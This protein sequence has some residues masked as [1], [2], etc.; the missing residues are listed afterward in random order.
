MAQIKIEVKETGAKEAEKSLNKLGKTGAKTDKETQSLDKTYQ[1]VSTTMGKYTGIAKGVSLGLAA[2]GSATV[3]ATVKTAAYIVELDNQARLSKQSIADYEASAFAAEQYG[4]TVDQLSDAFKDVSEKVGEFIATGGGG[5]ADFGDVM[6]MTKDET[7]AFAKEVEHLSGQEVLQRMTNELES[8]GASSAQMSFAL[9]GMASYLTLLQPLLVDNGSELKRLTTA[10][11]ELTIPIDEE[12]VASFRGLNEATGLLTGAMTSLLTSG[13][14]PMVDS[15]TALAE[16]TAH[17]VASLNEGTQAQL[18][19]D[20]V[21]LDDRAKEL[22]AT[23]E[24]NDDA[25]IKFG[26]N[27][28]NKLKTELAEVEAKYLATQK[29]LADSRVGSTDAEFEFEGPLPQ[30]AEQKAAE[31]SKR[32]EALKTAKAKEEAARQAMEKAQELA[33]KEIASTQAAID[34]R[35]AALQASFLTEAEIA[36]QKNQLIL[37]SSLTEQEQMALR[38]QLWGEYNDSVTESARQAAEEQASIEEK[39]QADIDANNKRMSDAWSNLT[40][41]LKTSLGEQNALYK[42]SATINATIAAYDAA[43]SAYAALAPIPYVGPALGAAAAG[44]A[45]AAGLANVAKINSARMQGGQVTAGTPYNVNERSSGGNSEVFVPDS[46]GKIIPSHQV[47]NDSNQSG[48]LNVNIFNYGSDEVSAVEEDDGS[49]SI[50]IKKS[51]FND[52]MSQQGSNA[53]SSLN[54]AQSRTYKMT[55]A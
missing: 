10:M 38:L 8:A 2:I 34:A 22:R 53:N 52:L 14:N 7:T 5:M 24:G 44:V 23:I 37:D 48:G 41:D 25:W 17:W 43:N 40:G 29:K 55:R 26:D 30:T 12:D 47:G 1:S 9:E 28:L 27:D 39:K 54:Q 45:V 16:A 33:D 31:E 36:K 15:M 46:N 32:L 6:G 11:D 13:M 4:L 20:L 3:L 21:D 50:Y 42:A 51:E 18:A 19:S 49:T 35:V